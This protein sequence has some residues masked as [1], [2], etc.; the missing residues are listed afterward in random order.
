MKT[1]FTTETRHRSLEKVLRVSCGELYG[2]RNRIEVSNSDL[3]STIK[4]VRY[5][6]RVD[7]ALQQTFA[8]F[9]QSTGEDFVIVSSGSQNEIV[10]GT[11]RLHQ[12]FHLQ[13]RRP[14]F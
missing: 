8:L 9:K 13:S 2:V 1:H 12:W 4:A 6:D 5:P 7:T 3:A 11:H 14:D 10:V